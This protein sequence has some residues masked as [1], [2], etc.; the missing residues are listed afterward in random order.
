M[1]VRLTTILLRN[2]RTR[3]SLKASNVPLAWG[4][5][6]PGA[7]LL[8]F[9]RIWRLWAG[10]AAH[11]EDAD[12]AAGCRFR[13][14]ARCMLEVG[15]TSG[16]QGETQLPHVDETGATE[17]LE[18]DLLTFSRRGHYAHAPLGAIGALD[19]TSAGSKRAHGRGLVYQ[20]CLSPSIA[21][22]PG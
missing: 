9:F 16:C 14:S 19:A 17:A 21:R 2:G 13:K 12:H 1:W 7:G 4:C 10:F 15:P 11:F 3:W 6:R 5:A 8:E 18:S 20:T 22:A